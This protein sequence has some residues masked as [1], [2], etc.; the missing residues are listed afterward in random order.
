R[1]AESPGA[2]PSATSAFRDPKVYREGGRFVLLLEDSAGRPERWALPAS[3]RAIEP[4]PGLPGN[5]RVTT[6]REERVPMALVPGGFPVGGGKG[7]GAPCLMEC[8]E[9]TV[10][11]FERFRQSASLRPMEEV[12]PEFRVPG[13]PI[14]IVSWDEA[15]EFAAW[16]EKSLP[17]ALEHEAA[18]SWDGTG[19]RRFPWGD[20]FEAGGIALEW[21][22]R[23]PPAEG[24]TNPGES[25]AP[26]SGE[27]RPRDVSAWGI[28]GLAGGVREWCLDAP[29]GKPDHRV[30]RGGSVVHPR[31]SWGARKPI[32]PEHFLA[33]RQDFALRSSKMNDVG[34]RCVIRL[35]RAAPEPVPEKDPRPEGGR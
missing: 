13:Q 2:A 30:I 19:R 17:S 5:F 6:S 21:Q 14:V 28:V 18:A 22:S 25:T 24:V 33:T 4:I 12:A 23:P 16:A 20:D 35:Q 15:V 3:V 26:V 10:E 8:F 11:R 31:G 32:T 27:A 9:V 1:E 29:E 7:R 34:V